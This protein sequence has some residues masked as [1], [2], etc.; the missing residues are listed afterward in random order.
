MR[1]S[2][3]TLR[4]TVILFQII[5]LMSPT[6]AV[7]GQLNV[8]H[9]INE[10]INGKSCDVTLKYCVEQ[11]CKIPFRKVRSGIQ[12]AY[13]FF[14]KLGYTEKFPVTIVFKPEINV[15]WSG[16]DDKK[17]VRVLGKYD[18]EEKT[19]YLTCWRDKW[20]SGRNDFYLDMTYEFYRTIVAHEMIHFLANRFAKN[21]VNSI[22][23]EYI[24]YSGQIELLPEET[25]RLLV[26]KYKI[27]PFEEY[28]IGEY[29]FV[30]DPGV[31]GLKSYL[32]Y[33]NSKGL[34]VKQILDGSVK[35]QPNI[36]PPY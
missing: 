32:H 17:S 29:L 5:C 23:S 25:V 3:S 36:W 12:S 11:K 30:M 7:A 15:D 31:F 16:G 28:E 1:T 19:I 22:L 8:F 10:G 18:E 9:T 21:S 20:I 26:E 4:Y 13:A 2:K 14:G 6:F 33:K 27:Q 34:L 35:E 24:A